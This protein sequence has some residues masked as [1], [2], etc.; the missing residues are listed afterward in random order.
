MIYGFCADASHTAIIMTNHE[1]SRQNTSLH[2]HA[3]L[4]KASDG[5]DLLNPSDWK[6]VL[7][8]CVSALVY[9]QTKNILHNDIKSDN[10]IIER[11]EP[12]V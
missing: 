9:L 5:E 10:I 6:E 2:I 11:L 4:Q 3:G 12:V 1:Y 8:G 7:I